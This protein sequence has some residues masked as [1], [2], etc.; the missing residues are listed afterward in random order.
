M[1]AT[2]YRTIYTGLKQTEIRNELRQVLKEADLDDSQLLREVSEAQ[3][4]EEERLGKMGESSNRGVNI[5]C[6]R[7]S[8]NIS[9]TIAS[10]MLSARRS[11]CII[12]SSFR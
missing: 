10:K 5:N 7:S 2:F 9:Q 1:N 6:E 3:A 8:R 4:R 12:S 11:P